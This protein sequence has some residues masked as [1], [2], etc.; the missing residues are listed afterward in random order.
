MRESPRNDGKGPRDNVKRARNGGR[1]PRKLWET[2]WA[3][4]STDNERLAR[5]LFPGTE[6]KTRRERES[7][8]R[9]N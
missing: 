9:E 5:K 6:R 2:T 3:P 1:S 8:E 4:G 7:R